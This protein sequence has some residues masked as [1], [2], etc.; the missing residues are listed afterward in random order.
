MKD[1]NN[2]EHKINIFLNFLLITSSYC[3]S[4]SS[5]SQ[6]PETPMTL[7]FAN[8][9][10]TSL[11]SYSNSDYPISPAEPVARSALSPPLSHQS[12]VTR[13]FRSIQ[14]QRRMEKRAFNSRTPSLLGGVS[15]GKA[16]LSFVRA[17]RQCLS[18][19]CWGRIWLGS[20]CFGDSLFRDLRW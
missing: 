14:G 19:K 8:N 15:S 13:S 7:F 4:S 17:Y 9:L 5:L 1:I 20:T 12:S 3:P 11:P 16:L 6:G 18:R 2:L 10:H